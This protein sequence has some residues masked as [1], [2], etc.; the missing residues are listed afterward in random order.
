MNFKVLRAQRDRS[1]KQSHYVWRTSTGQILVFRACNLDWMVPYICVAY[2][3]ARNDWKTWYGKKARVHEKKRE[4]APQQWI[5]FIHFFRIFAVSQN[6][7]ITPFRNALFPMSTNSKPLSHPG[8]SRGMV[9]ASKYFPQISK[10]LEKVPFCN[11]LL[12]LNKS[13]LL[14][15]RH[16]RPATWTV[17]KMMLPI[18]EF[19]FCSVVVLC[20]VLV[21]SWVVILLLW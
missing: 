2:I 19:L 14:T 4:S 11:S 20:R 6:C 3:R 17:T 16:S 5:V 12:F 15:F 21:V 9:P 13:N 8:L 1:A 18:P 10:E 7:L